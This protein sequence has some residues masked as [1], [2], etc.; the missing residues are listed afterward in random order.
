MNLRS[1][2]M[3]ASV[4]IA[5]AGLLSLTSCAKEPCRTPGDGCAC[6]Q[7]TGGGEAALVMLTD[8]KSEAFLDAVNRLTVEHSEALEEI[9]LHRPPVVIL[10]TYDGVGEVSE[11]AAFDLSGEGQTV[12]R[13]A[14][15][16]EF[17]AACLVQ[18][19]ESVPSDTPGGNLLR[20]LPAASDL[21]AARGQSEAAVVAFGLGRSALDDPTMDQDLP[22]DEIDLTTAG[23]QQHVVDVLH[24]IGLLPVSERVI[25]TFVDPDEGVVNVVVAGYIN[26]FAKGPL[27]DGV[28]HGRCSAKEV[29]K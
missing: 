29:L 13:K 3:V 2:T 16:A 10:A 22:M 17:A 11:V 28:G 26:E 21:A 1:I 27:C 24:E 4:A 19:A 18:A 20:A 7:A 9:G 23:A 12:S 5:S 15:N 25:V 14:A 8:G 6:T